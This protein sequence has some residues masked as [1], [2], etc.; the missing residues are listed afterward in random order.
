[1]ALR[2][3]ARSMTPLGARTATFRGLEIE[4]ALSG[5][6]CLAVFSSAAEPQ[7]FA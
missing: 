3:G 4:T 7:H 6:D 2:P 1:M 5:R